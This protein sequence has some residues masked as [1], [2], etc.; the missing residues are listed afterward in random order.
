MLFECVHPGVTICH[1]SIKGKF[2]P[3]CYCFSW[4]TWTSEGSHCSKGGRGLI[5]VSTWRL[6][7]RKNL[8]VGKTGVDLILWQVQMISHH[9]SL[10]WG[11]F[12]VIFFFFLILWFVNRRLC[13]CVRAF[14][15]EFYLHFDKPSIITE[16]TLFNHTPSF[17]LCFD[18]ISFFLLLF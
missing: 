11:F 10:E 16:L 3:L 18:I 15:F 4:E 1:V 6:M 14:R 13:F 17:C 8:Q 5:S 7:A 12:L 2:P 9:K